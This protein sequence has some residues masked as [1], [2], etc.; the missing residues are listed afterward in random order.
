MVG[1]QS[2]FS[3][4]HYGELR[5]WILPN[6]NLQITMSSKYFVRPDNSKKGNY[7]EPDIYIPM[8]CTDLINGRDACWDWILKNY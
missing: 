6:T 1:E 3:A 4:T 7:I 8:T 2:T 5:F